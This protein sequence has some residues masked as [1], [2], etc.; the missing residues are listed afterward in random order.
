MPFLFSLIHED[1]TH[2]SP[3][4]CVIIRVM[5]LQVSTC[6]ILPFWTCLWNWLDLVTP[7]PMAVP[8]QNT[9]IHKWNQ[10]T[11]TVCTVEKPSRLGK[12][13]AG[14][15]LDA[16]VISLSGSSFLTSLIALNPIRRDAGFVC[17]SMKA[18]TK[19]SLKL[20]LENHPHNRVILVVISNCYCMFIC[21]QMK[22]LHDRR[23]CLKV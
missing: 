23:W 17:I 11:H 2:W 3:W 16:P 9:K 1:A 18:Y 4:I 22:T 7:H 19:N 21:C 5:S 15:C 14:V 10:W 13:R 20:K 8:V 12:R 6:P